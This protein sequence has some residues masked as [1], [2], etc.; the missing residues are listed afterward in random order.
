MNSFDKTEV[1]VRA[2]FP[3]KFRLK[4]RR[5][6]AGDNESADWNRKSV[7]EVVSQAIGNERVEKSVINQMNEL[8]SKQKERHGITGTKTVDWFTTKMK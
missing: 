3:G 1:E 8:K 7:L 6:F 4:S 2:N 5:K